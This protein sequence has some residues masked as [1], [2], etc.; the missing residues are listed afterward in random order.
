MVTLLGRAIVAH[1]PASARRVSCFHLL[2]SDNDH[3]MG[4]A[5]Y[6]GGKRCVIFAS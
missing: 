5:N 3:N 1:A 6:M 4:G 2:R